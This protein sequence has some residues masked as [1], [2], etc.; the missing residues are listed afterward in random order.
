MEL[1]TLLNVLPRCLENPLVIQP[2]RCP[3]IR[4]TL[5]P[6][7]LVSLFAMMKA[8]QRELRPLTEFA[9]ILDRYRLGAAGQNQEHMEN[10]PGALVAVTKLAGLTTRTGHPS[11]PTYA[12]RPA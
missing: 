7:H 12:T 9:D 8:Y 10:R 2:V 6:L 11:A 5:L 4:G 1:A 3:A